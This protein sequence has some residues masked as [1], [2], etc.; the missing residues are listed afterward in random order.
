MAGLVV[1]L[2]VL[3]LRHNDDDQD[4]EEGEAADGDEPAEL[5]DPNF[6]QSL[7]GKQG[8]E[9]LPRGSRRARGGTVLD[10][11]DSDRDR[12]S[13]EDEVRGWKRVR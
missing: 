1:L 10:D 11:S 6:W 12:S 3:G 8:A 9:A 5:S 2:P 4:S 13:D 7:L